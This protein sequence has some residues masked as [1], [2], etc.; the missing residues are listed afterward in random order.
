VGS[1]TDD[2]LREGSLAFG[3]GSLSDGAAGG[4]FGNRVVSSVS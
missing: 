1:V 4:R 3:V 2:R